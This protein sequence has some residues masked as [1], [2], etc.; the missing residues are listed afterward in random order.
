MTKFPVFHVATLALILLVAAVLRFYDL[1]YRPM[2]GDEANQA[3]KTSVLLAKGEYAY[4]PF[5]HHGPTL[6]Y[7][8]LPILWIAGAHNAAEMTEPM[9]RLVP[10]FF[11]LGLVLLSW[12]IVSPIDRRAGLWAALLTAV[13][14]GLVYYSRYYVQEISFVFF[15]AGLLWCGH[16]Y[17]SSRRIGWA[18]G[19]GLCLGLLHATKETSVLVVFAMVAALACVVAWEKFV[20]RRAIALTL[21]WRHLGAGLGLALAISVLFFSS[22][23]THWRGPLDSLL[24]YTTYLNRAEGHGSS[25]LHDQPWYYYI[26]LLA[27]TYREAGPKW[28]EGLILGLGLIG[29]LWG[30]WG[31][32]R[33][34]QTDRTDRDGAI[35]DCGAAFPRFL[36]LYTLFLVVGFSLIP[37]KTPWNLL[38]FLHPLCLLAGLGAQC[39]TG[40]QRAVWV[41][42]LFGV[43]ILA[44]TAQLAGQAWR[45][46]F[47]YG[48]DVRNPY[49]YAHTSS[50]IRRLTE[51]VTDLAAVH[52]RGDQIHINVFRFDGDYWP[53]PWYLRRY[54]NVGYWPNF[55]ESPDA[56]VILT[57]PEIAGALQPRLKDEYQ[58]EMNGLRPGVLM[59][60]FIRKE[61]WDAFMA[62]RSGPAET[63]P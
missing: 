21:N 8:T 7:L 22:F 9:I 58:V 37:Y 32:N 15:A 54:P 16:H 60:T 57:S 2:H 33:T 55:P 20:A 53:L 59:P 48:A 26:S 51:R 36:A 28:S 29:V 3:M 13:S 38:I 1:G 11:G 12:L 24:T 49:V 47:T 45:G 50:A 6:Y 52:P 5:E 25:A 19:A 56:D 35:V 61:L 17:L 41:R 40:L 23:F 34:D 31:P 10:A 46:S 44:A 63:A 62:K 30:L 27:W 4:D 39:L 18:L 42:F 14:H 43:L